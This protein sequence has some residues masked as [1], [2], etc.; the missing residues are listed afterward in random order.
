MEFFVYINSCSQNSQAYQYQTKQ[1]TFT[2]LKNVNYK[3]L[4]APIEVVEDAKLVLALKSSP[5][6][7]KFFEKFDAVAS[8]RSERFRRNYSLKL[9]YKPVQSV[10]PSLAEKIKKFIANPK[11]E[12]FPF[13]TTFSVENSDAAAELLY[14]KIKMTTFDELMDK[15]QK[16]LDKVI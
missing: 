14:E 10:E 7:N 16:I 1:P 15:H 13:E 2:A 8:F 4:F 3:G 5:A 6:F 9:E 12:K 11:G